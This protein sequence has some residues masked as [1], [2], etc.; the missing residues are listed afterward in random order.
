M[1]KIF[2]LLIFISS[3]AFAVE[4]NFDLTSRIVF[5]PRVTVNNSTAYNNVQLLLGTNGIWSILAAEPEKSTT[6]DTPEIDPNYD[7]STGIVIFP[8]VTVNNSTA[9]NNVQLLLGTNGIWS[10]LAAEQEELASLTG[11]YTGSTNSNVS[12]LYNAPVLSN[13]TQ[14]G[15]QLT[16]DVS[17]SNMLGSVNGSMT[18]EIDGS[19]VT[20]TID[21]PTLTSKVSFNGLISNDNKTLSGSYEWPAI[22]DTGTWLLTKQ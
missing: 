6:D 22:N 3:S 15:N 21:L 14:N 20:L 18:G 11:S 19:N 12:P 2:T 13:I 4:P 8:R 10:I 1:K 9:Y 16:G 7:T 17:I 5:F